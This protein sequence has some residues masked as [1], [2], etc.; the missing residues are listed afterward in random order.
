VERF[1]QSEQQTQLVRQR[2]EVPAY[3]EQAR[4]ICQHRRHLI[5]HL[6]A[7]LAG[8]VDDPGGALCVTSMVASSDDNLATTFLSITKLYSAVRCE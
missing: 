4:F 8:V 5:T 1:A 7:G 6:E 2:G 3:V